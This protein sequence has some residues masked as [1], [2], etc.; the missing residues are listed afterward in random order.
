MPSCSPLHQARSATIQSVWRLKSS[1][2]TRKYTYFRKNRVQIRKSPAA[3]INS[4]ATRHS[5]DLVPRPINIRHA[6]RSTGHMQVNIIKVSVRLFDR[7]S[8]ILDALLDEVSLKV[9]ILRGLQLDSQLSDSL[10]SFELATC[11][12]LFVETANG[13]GG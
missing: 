1:L 13:T 5:A 4:L 12:K 8:L 2:K 7:V 9:P 6:P 10:Q 11:S 3:C